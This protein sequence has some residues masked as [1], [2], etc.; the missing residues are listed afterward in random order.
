MS[1]YFPRNRYPSER[2]FDALEKLDPELQEEEDGSLYI[3][4][5]DL[6]ISILAEG[7]PPDKV[8]KRTLEVLEQVP[9]FDN[10]IQQDCERD[11]SKSNLSPDGFQLDLVQVYAFPDRIEL[12]Y[13]GTIVNTQW[14]PVFRK[15]KNGEWIMEES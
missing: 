2:L 5:D 1:N 6:D 11:W 12:T 15:N 9:I 3:Q 14:V 13:Y 7:E 4:V 10:Q 8:L